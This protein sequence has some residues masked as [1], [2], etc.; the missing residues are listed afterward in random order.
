MVTTSTPVLLSHGVLSV[1]LVWSSQVTS[2]YVGKG[3]SRRERQSEQTVGLRVMVEISLCLW[4]ERGGCSLGTSYTHTHP[5]RIV[6]GPVGRDCRI[7]CPP[8]PYIGYTE[9]RVSCAR[10]SDKDYTPPPWLGLISQLCW[11]MVGGA[12]KQLYRQRHQQRGGPS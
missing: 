9:G 11:F 1:A 8:Y 3:N 10:P 2:V 7:S 6:H 5:P 12:I 4:A